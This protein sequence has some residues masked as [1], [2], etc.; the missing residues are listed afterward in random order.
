[1]GQVSH[2]PWIPDQGQVNNRSAGASGILQ[3]ADAIL[4]NRGPLPVTRDVSVRQYQSHQF[5]GVVQTA[6]LHPFSTLTD[7]GVSNGSVAVLAHTNQ[8]VARVSAVISEGRT[9]GAARLPAIDHEVVWD[10]ELSLAAAVVV[11][12]VLTWPEQ[13]EVDAI[14][15]TLAAAEDFFKVKGGE[16]ARGTA[17]TLLR[18]RQAIATGRQPRSD[19]AKKLLSSYAAGLSY[20]GRPVEDWTPR[21][22]G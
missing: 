22:T 9:F 10:A 3:L 4:R 21:I 17:E 6:V 5:E 12:S 2:S 20:T 8:M 13:P 1:M 18:A 16:T 15:A 19:T 7:R 11:A 14:S